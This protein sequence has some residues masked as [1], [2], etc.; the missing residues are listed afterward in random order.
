MKRKVFILTITILSAFSFAAC[1]AQRTIATVDS[2][3]TTGIASS[4]ST[5]LFGDSVGNFYA[6]GGA[7]WTYHDSDTTATGIPAVQGDKVIFAQVDG[8]I[9]CLD[10]PSGSFVWRY[11]PAIDESSNDGL[12]DGAA[13]G[14]GLVYAAFT[15]GALRAFDLKDGHLVWTYNASQGLRTAPVYSSGMVFLGEYDGLFSMIEAKTGRR[16]NGG[17]AGGALN[18]PAVNGGNVYYSAWDG[19][20]H[21]VQIKDV[22]PLWDAKAGEPVTTAPV[23][24]EGIIA[25]GTAGGKVIAFDE[26]TGGKLWEY[27]SEGGQILAR[28]VISGSKILIATGDGKIA[29]LSSKTGK[30]IREHAGSYGLS[31]AGGSTLYYVNSEH[32][33]C[34][35]N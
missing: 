2:F 7:S 9:T 26:K 11:T 17:G 30:L 15:S 29:E 27:A 25:V 23:V 5:L 24:G 10:I 32:E 19:S 1:A 8:T 22:I 28:P 16:V 18:T 4:G 35:I 34:A 33:L 12:N 3:I 20:I 13:V 14:G 21:A 31:A 6:A